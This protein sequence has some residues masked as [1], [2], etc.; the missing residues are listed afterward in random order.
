M[1]RLTG[2]IRT[3]WRTRAEVT[4]VSR[5]RVTNCVLFG[6]SQIGARW[7]FATVFYSVRPIVAAYRHC[8]IPDQGS[9]GGR[10]ANKDKAD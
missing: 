10:R 5:D 7:V 2:I 9:A 6:T 1:L 8:V 3:I 4:G